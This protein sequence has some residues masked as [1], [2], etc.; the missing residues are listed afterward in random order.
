MG[1]SKFKDEYR[2]FICFYDDD[3]VQ[4]ELF[5]KVLEASS[6]LRFETQDGNVIT[7]P[8]HRVKKVKQKKSFK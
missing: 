5:V 3:D 1:V 2:D 4:K 8:M 7:I 6:I